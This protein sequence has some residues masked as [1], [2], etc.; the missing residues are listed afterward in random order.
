MVKKLIGYILAIAGLIAVAASA[1]EKIRAFLNPIL[2]QQIT[3]FYL[4]IGGIILVL[5]GIFFVLKAGKS[6]QK[7]VEVP[8]YEG[9]MIVGYRKTR[10]T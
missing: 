1:I 2:P 4:T 7:L 10:K 9:N 5:I 8:I 3:N 6:K